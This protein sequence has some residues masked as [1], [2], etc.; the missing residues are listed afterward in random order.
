M[1]AVIFLPLPLLCSLVA[2]TQ[3]TSYTILEGGDRLQSSLDKDQ[4]R[5]IKINVEEA[6]TYMKIE[7]TVEKQDLGNNATVVFVLSTEV[8]VKTWRISSGRSGDSLEYSATLLPTSMA[9]S[10]IKLAIST[11]SEGKCCHCEGSAGKSLN[12][13][14]VEQK[15]SVNFTVLDREEVVL[16]QSKSL[17]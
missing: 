7:T 1:S 3:S 12:Y 13:I 15:Y 4:D 16:K 14:L 11:K 17:S 8:S 10:S 2:G 5:E 6:G 9:N